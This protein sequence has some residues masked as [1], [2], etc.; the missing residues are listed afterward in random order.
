MT[1]ASLLDQV[2]KWLLDVM[3]I[4]GYP[5]VFAALFLEGAWV[6]ITS[7][8][9]LLTAGFLAF[10]GKMNFLVAALSGAAGFATG[11]FVP[12]LLARY[13]GRP[14]LV[15]WGR[16]VFVTPEDVERVEKWFTR[17]GP[18][19]ILLTRMIP[20]VRN[21]ISF[22]AGMGRL[23]PA[24][25]FLL[26]IVGFGP[27][28]VFVTYA[29]MKM[30]ANWET[31]LQLVDGLSVFGWIIIGGFAAALIGFLVYRRRAVLSAAKR[32]GEK[33]EG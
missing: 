21:A 28:A 7:E 33:S 13:K 5:A 30:G 22:P 18:R 24:Y 32:R 19:V 9:F 10:Q 20:V 1:L 6:P 11:C 25:F 15:R 14:F 16:Y 31:I 8:I 29:G 23:H 2:V 3:A 12:F 27:W 4:L 17:Y 26:T